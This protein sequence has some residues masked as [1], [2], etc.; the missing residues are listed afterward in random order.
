MKWRKVAANQR[1]APCSMTSCCCD[2]LL[3][4]RPRER[5]ELPADSKASSQRRGR[6]DSSVTVYCSADGWL[7]SRATTGTRSS[8]LSTLQTLLNSFIFTVKVKDHSTFSPYI[9]NNAETAHA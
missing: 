7:P 4:S 8:A 2:N 3:P 5:G 6:A 1:D 9:L